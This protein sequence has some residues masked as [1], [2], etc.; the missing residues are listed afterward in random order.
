MPKKIRE[1][2]A[3]LL[4]AGFVYRPAKGSHTF[5]THPL[6]LDEPITIAGKD[7]DDAPRY[8]EKQVNRVLKQL[9]EVEEE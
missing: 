5:W 7:G 8:L 4:K 6:I 2:K 3:I 9:G 1:L